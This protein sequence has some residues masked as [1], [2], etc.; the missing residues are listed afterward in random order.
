MILYISLPSSAKQQ[1][2]MSKFKVF[3]VW[4]MWA[5]IR[6]VN[7]SFS[8]LTWTPFLSGLV[9]GYF[10]HIAQLERIR[11]ITKRSSRSNA[12]LVSSDVFRC[13]CRRCCLSSLL[14]WS[15]TP[16]LLEMV[17]ISFLF[18]HKLCVVKEKAT[19]ISLL[20]RI[21]RLQAISLH[22]GLSRT[23]QMQL[24]FRWIRKKLLP[25]WWCWL[26]DNNAWKHSV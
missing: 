12:K 23:R 10:A 9:S 4:R 19:S 11:I 5:H 15:G 21:T 8:F 18:F 3:S 7:F 24:R 25:S 2:E 20:H 16:N 17:R 1:R 13:R 6:P 22:R 26:G 14:S